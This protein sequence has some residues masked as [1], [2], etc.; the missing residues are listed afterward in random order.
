MTRQ[1]GIRRGS[2]ALLLGGLVLSLALS[3]AASARELNVW[4]AEYNP[5]LATIMEQE[6]LPEFEA[7]YGVDVVVT[8]VGWD[9]MES[10]LKVATAAGTPPDIFE[11]GNQAREFYSAGLLADLTS[12]YER[13]GLAEEFFQPLLGPVTIGGRLYAV[14]FTYDVRTIF[15]LSHV[16]EQAG[17][18]SNA[19]PVTWDDLIEYTRRLTR[20]EGN[21]VTR[22]GYA[23]ERLTLGGVTTYQDFQPY[24]WQA[25]G[26]MLD[27]ET[28]A[29]R[30]H[31]GPGVETVT[32]LRELVRLSH[33]EGTE[34]LVRQ[35]STNFINGQYG[36]YYGGVWV[37]KFTQDASPELSAN[38]RAVVPPTRHREPAAIVFVN[39][40]AVHPGSS[41]EDLAW[42]LLAY[43]MQPEH[44]VRINDALGA[45]PPLREVALDPDTYGSR[46]YRPYLEAVAYARG[47]Y[48][49]PERT[50][51]SMDVVGN[52]VK[53]A[54]DGEMAPETALEQA[55]HEWNAI[56]SSFG[57]Q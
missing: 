38:L 5:Q 32:L 12:Y 23:L 2:L 44:I 9:Q 48:G 39:W 16:W 52:W 7:R 40:L 24:L 46:I 57:Q 21:A 22:E 18:D 41:Q 28:L 55:A 14:P 42:E 47:T 1:F 34:P 53:R 3:P 25:G 17:L 54:L 10:K 50:L 33:P 56:I 45:P 6:I 13:S 37:A 36:M 49:L 30:F 4:V 15:Y 8:V 19:P 51:Y 29:P 31:E 35:F 26:T 43:L 11:W 27:E 20:V